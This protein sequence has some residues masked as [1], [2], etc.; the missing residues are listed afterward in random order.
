MTLSSVRYFWLQKWL[1]I[2]SYS[3]LDD[4]TEDSPVDETLEDADG[5]DKPQNMEF[6]PCF[7]IQA[8]KQLVSPLILP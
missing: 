2:T 3:A 1:Y 5:P 7:E 6:N 4:P 8:V